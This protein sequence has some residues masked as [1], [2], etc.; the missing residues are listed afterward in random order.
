M[1][2]SAFLPDMKIILRCISKFNPPECM[3][4]F[5][6][7]LIRSYAMNDMRGF[8]RSEDVSKPEEGL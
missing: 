4:A 2:P 7:R 8:S 6:R 3:Q 1:L 5:F